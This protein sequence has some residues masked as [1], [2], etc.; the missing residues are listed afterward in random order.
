MGVWDLTLDQRGMPAPGFYTYGAG[1]N[2]SGTF[3]CSAAIGVNDM[4]TINNIIGGDKAPL[5]FEEHVHHTN[6]VLACI[7]GVYDDPLTSRESLVRGGNI[8]AFATA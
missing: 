1:V 2:K 5:E 3:N 4:G 7:S 8:F 6:G